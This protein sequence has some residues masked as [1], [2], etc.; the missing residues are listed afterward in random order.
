MN[1]CYLIISKTIAKEQNLELKCCGDD[2]NI[3]S[4]L[5]DNVSDIEFIRSGISSRCNLAGANIITGG[6]ITFKNINS[7]D[8]ELKKV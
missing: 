7:N 1:L 3:A 2:I 5:Q 8:I 4:K 6:S